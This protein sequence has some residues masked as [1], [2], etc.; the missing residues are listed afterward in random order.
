MYAIQLIENENAHERSELQNETK[1][2]KKRYYT[3][4]QH[5]PKAIQNNNTVELQWLEHFWDQE[6]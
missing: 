4:A 2:L 1:K 3:S 5:T 6:N